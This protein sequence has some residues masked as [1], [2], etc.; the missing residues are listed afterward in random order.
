MMLLMVVMLIVVMTHDDINSVNNGN[1]GDAGVDDDVHNGN[2][3]DDESDVR[4]PII[5]CHL[6][7][8]QQQMVRSR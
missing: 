6:F 4:R 8:R 7:T 3:D 1:Y 2:G 5:T